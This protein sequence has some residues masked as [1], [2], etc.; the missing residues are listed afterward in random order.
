MKE[1][2]SE[3]MDKYIVE[4]VKVK[5]PKLKKSELKLPK[6]KRVEA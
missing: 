1:K 2:F 4:E 6:L 5:L 3:I